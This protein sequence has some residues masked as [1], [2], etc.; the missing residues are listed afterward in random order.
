[1]IEAVLDPKGD[2]FMLKSD[3]GFIRNWVHA[4]ALVEILEA[5]GQRQVTPIRI[6]NGSAIWGGAAIRAKGA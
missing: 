2:V 6:L 4:V 5:T 1:M 3:R